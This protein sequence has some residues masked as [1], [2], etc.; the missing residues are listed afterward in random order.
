MLKV[1]VKAKK[2]ERS[3]DGNENPFTTPVTPVTPVSDSAPA[4]RTDHALRTSAPSDLYTDI[5]DHL[6]KRWVMPGEKKRVNAEDTKEKICEAQYFLDRMVENQNKP[7][8]FKYNLS[9]FLN[10]FRSIRDFMNRELKDTK[11]EACNEKLKTWM[12]S[13]PAI[14]LLRKS[15]NITTHSRII[16]THNDV[17][18]HVTDNRK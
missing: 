4:D 18:V 6:S 13:D 15:R 17:N 12:D 1:K 9:A 8:P 11:L 10:A 14:M 5:F 3:E 7:R 16:R 2:K